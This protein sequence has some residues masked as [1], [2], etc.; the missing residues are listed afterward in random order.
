MQMKGRHDVKSFFTLSINS[1]CCSRIFVVSSPNCRFDCPP[2]TMAFLSFILD[3]FRKPYKLR[4]HI[5]K[6]F[7]GHCKQQMSFALRFDSFLIGA[8]LLT[9]E[10]NFLKKV[11]ERF[12]NVF[13]RIRLSRS[14]RLAWPG[15]STLERL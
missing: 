6:K 10:F 11:C 9:K 2:R 14:S 4:N 5:T 8:F 13:W 7:N 1:L 15:I 3:S 12:V